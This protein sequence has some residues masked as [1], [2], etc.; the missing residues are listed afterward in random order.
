MKTNELKKGDIVAISG[1]YKAEIMDNKKGNI[2]LIKTFPPLYE[3]IGS[4]YAWEISW[5]LSN[6]NGEILNEKIELTPAQEK[7][8][9]KTN[10]FLGSF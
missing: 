10:S 6:K 8:K 7:A 9:K 1:G 2:R 4:I 5:I 3:E